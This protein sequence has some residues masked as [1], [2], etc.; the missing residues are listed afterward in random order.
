MKR[1]I[2][3]VERLEC[4]QLMAADVV[5][6]D[7]LL[8]ESRES[9]FEVLEVAPTVEG[10]FGGP[11]TE[12]FDSSS[13][14]LPRLHPESK[15]GLLPGPSLP[16]RNNTANL[17]ITSATIADGV[18]VP[19]SQLLVGQQ[20]VLRADW[21]STNTSGFNYT[22][23]FYFNGTRVDS[24]QITGTGGNTSYWWYR[25]G[26]F[27]RPGLHTLTIVVDPDNI[28]PES[29][30]NDNSITFQIA[31]VEPT[32]LPSRFRTPIGRT[33]NRDWA[34]NNYADIDPRPGSQA[35]YRN[36]PFQYD[37]HNAIDAGPWGFSSQDAGI[38]ILA[39]ADGFVDAV[40]DGYFDRETSI[41]NRPG[42]F[43]RIDHGNG[44]K[45]LYYHFAT[46][47]ITVQLGQ[48]VRTG[49]LLGHM[50]SSGSST[51]THLHF[52][53]YYRDAPIETGYAPSIYQVDPLPYGGDVAP[54]F[55]ETGITNRM[56]DSDSSEHVSDNSNFALGSAGT[57]S[58]W[59]QAY[60]LKSGDT[61]RWRYFRPD[62]SLFSTNTFT[63]NASY[64]F[65]WWYWNR[66]LGSFSST[67]G[68]WRMEFSINDAV[69]DSKTFTISTTGTAAIRLTGSGVGLINSKRT[70]PIDY[71]IHSGGAP[72]RTFTMENHGTTPLV[73]GN[74]KLPR[75]FKLVGNF[76]QSIAAGTSVNFTVALDTSI[77]GNKF[78]AI[79]FTTN[80]PDTPQFWFNV[81]GTVS[82]LD[83]GDSITVSIP[84]PARPLYRGADPI[85]VAP[86]SSLN[87]SSGVDLRNALLRVE[88]DNAPGDEEWL[89]LPPSAIAAEH[90]ASVTGGGKGR[91]LTVQFN[92]LA[93]KANILRTLQRITYENR[94]N[95]WSYLRRYVR[96]TLTDASG[97]L[98]GDAIA[99]LIPGEKLSKPGKLEMPQM[100]QTL[101]LSQ[102]LS[103][104]EKERLDPGPRSY[105][106]GTM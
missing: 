60:N 54:F 37:G 61:L 72:S 103:E 3:R 76:P 44:F 25:Y 94:S 64:R 66:T 65:S 11:R 20:I 26:S 42:N 58:F 86:I 87:V 35:D 14:F 57:L 79:S 1:P 92:T 62:G 22:V 24:G 82:G 70:T 18:G 2:L 106:D 47:S 51:G 34:I 63:L 71:G 77:V 105:D 67:L 95:H 59:L 10:V 46:H 84:G 15:G 78:G 52:T 75:G 55:L 9:E 17:R 53:P 32:N 93:T 102:F 29:N 96:F 73:V 28:V 90:I 23:G 43:V 5:A 45:T 38:P 39:A 100:I 101:A 4:R 50:G 81:S 12:K 83:P 8:N 27:A 68:N 19:Q 97:I 91:A 36:G 40:Q 88:V 74:L 7:P 31:T 41:G 6:F 99:N 30:E 13:K 16:V 98:S 33:A 69:F 48:S 104:I 49:Q 21:A 56:V 85:V 89:T 80:D